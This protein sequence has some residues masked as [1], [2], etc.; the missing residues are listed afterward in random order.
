MIESARL[1]IQPV[2]E[3][4]VLSKLQLFADFHL[5]PDRELLNPDAWLGN[6]KTTERP[7]ALNVLHVYLH[8][9]DRL[10]NA[11]FRAALH[12]MSGAVTCHANS[13]DE[14]STLW[15]TFLSSLTVTFVQ[16]ESPGPTDSGYLFARKARQITGMTQTNVV[17]P[18]VA[19]RTLLQD[20]VSPVLFVDDFIGSGQQMI[21]EWYRTHR[22]DPSLGASFSTATQSHSEVFYIPIIATSQGLDNV[23]EHC[24]ALKVRPVHILD[25]TY[26]LTSPD[27]ILWPTHLKSSANDVLFTASKRAGIL[28][29]QNVKWQGFR[30]LSLP[31]SFDHSVPDATLP[32]I[33]WETGDWKPLI[34]KS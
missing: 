14:A 32:L 17:Q 12:S 28:E 2:T 10:T 24:P 3:A 29:S 22:I 33:Y 31:L 5:W 1:P 27:S 4:F 25:S 34:R 20:P 7:Y 8:F 11:M 6:F 15:S 18:Q 19:L 16:G 30:N 9:N 21:V 23:A 13:P 26:S